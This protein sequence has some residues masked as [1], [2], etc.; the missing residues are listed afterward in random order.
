MGQTGDKPEGWGQVPTAA[1]LTSEQV[2][3]L[4]TSE[5]WSTREA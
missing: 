3:A 1:G 5:K 4:S 2:D